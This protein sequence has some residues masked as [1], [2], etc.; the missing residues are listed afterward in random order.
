MTSWYSTQDI[1]TGY[2]RNIRSSFPHNIAYYNISSLALQCCLSY[3]H[4][5][6]Y[7]RKVNA[8]AGHTGVRFN[9]SR[10]AVKIKQQ[11]I[12]GNAVIDG[13]V[14]IDATKKG[15]VYK[16]KIKIKNCS[17]TAT[18]KIG[19]ADIIKHTLRYD[20]SHYLYCTNGKKYFLDQHDPTHS[21]RKKYGDTFTTNDIITVIFNVSETSL[22]F[23]K[24]GNSQGI[25]FVDKHI[26]DYKQKYTLSIHMNG[27][28]TAV[29]LIGFGEQYQYIHYALCVDCDKFHG[30]KLQNW[31]C[32]NCFIQKENINKFKLLGKAGIVSKNEKQKYINAIKLYSKINIDR[33]VDIIAEYALYCIEYYYAGIERRNNQIRLDKW[34]EQNVNKKQSVTA[35]KMMIDR[36]SYDDF[37]NLLIEL[38]PWMSINDAWNVICKLGENNINWE[39]RVHGILQDFRVTTN[40]P[41]NVNKEAIEKVNKI[42]GLLYFVCDVYIDDGKQLKRV[43]EY[44]FG[45]HPASSCTTVE[46]LTNYGKGNGQYWIGRHI[47]KN[48]QMNTCFSENAPVVTKRELSRVTNWKW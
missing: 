35:L 29:L 20:Y 17:A 44:C 19:I 9:R 7:F 46:Y 8:Q 38:Q 18:I 28:N 13:K 47:I 32:S 27:N 3:Y 2:I 14:I 15:F 12:R 39:A 26:F 48:H 10:N 5:T 25:A 31:L 45:I 42:L 43:I 34:M 23:L 22:Q 37:V 1:V 40:Q 33:I 41:E 11:T 16:W 36:Q 21:I 30:T 6:E 4:S 24:N